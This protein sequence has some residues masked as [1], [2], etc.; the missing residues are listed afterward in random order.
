MTKLSARSV[1][2]VQDTP[3]AMEFY[4]NTLGF[5]LPESEHA[6]WRNVGEVS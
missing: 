3:R 1:F 6:K 2:F 4:T 5:W